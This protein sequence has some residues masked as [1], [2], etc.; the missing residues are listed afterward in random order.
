VSK[1][2]HFCA[3]ISFTV[4]VHAISSQNIAFTVTV[5]TI[6]HTIIAFAVTVE[7]SFGEEIVFAVTANGEV[8]REKGDYSDCVRG[9]GERKG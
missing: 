8:Y 3:E 7:A 5:G 1:N 6:S 9:D 4:T 2:T